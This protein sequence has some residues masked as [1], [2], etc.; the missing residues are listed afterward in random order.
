MS[1]IELVAERW[2]TPELAA[3]VRSATEAEHQR[4]G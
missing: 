2:E 3:E 4:T 1:T